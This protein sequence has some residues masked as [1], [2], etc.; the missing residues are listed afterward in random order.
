MS[1]SL[2]ELSIEN[3]STSSAFLRITKASGNNKSKQSERRN[4]RLKR[5]TFLH[6]ADGMNVLLRCEDSKSLDRGTI[7]IG[8]TFSHTSSTMTSK[9][10]NATEQISLLRSMIAPP[11]QDSASKQHCPAR[12]A[13][14]RRG[15]RQQNEKPQVTFVDDCEND[16]WYYKENVPF[17]IEDVWYT[18]SSSR[19]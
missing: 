11:I 10:S 13:Q 2:W 5:L 4:F 7:N 16:V 15:R 9:K 3:H 14:R 19:R 1:Y 8:S 12:F 17:Y 18:V 6:S